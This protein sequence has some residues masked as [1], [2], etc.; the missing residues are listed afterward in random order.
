MNAGVTVV[1]IGLVVVGG[2]QSGSLAGVALFG[3]LA[4]A[5][6]MLKG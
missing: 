3:A 5:A 6:G 1:Q 4:W 2:L